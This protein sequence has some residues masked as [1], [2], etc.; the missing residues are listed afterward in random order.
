MTDLSYKRPG[1]LIARG[2]V[3][4]PHAPAAEILDWPAPAARLLRPER[5]E[6]PAL[7]LDDVFGARWAGWARD[8]AA[9]KGA[10]PDYVV[11]GL[12][13]VAGSLIGNARWVS[14]WAG[15]AEPPILWVMLIGNPSA[16]KS[17]GLDAALGPLRALE[18]EVRAAEEVALADWRDR[19]RLA[20]LAEKAWEKAT[21]AAL[22]R[23][24][25]LPARPAA[26]DPGPKPTLPR[27]SV[28]DVAV[29]R[30][31]ALLEQ[32]L[33]GLLMARDE[34]S[35]WIHSMTRYSGGSDRPFWLEAYG[36]RPYTVE[37]MGREPV[38]V[39]HLSVGVVG[40]IQPDRL[41]KL[42]L[43]AGDDDGLVARVLPFWPDP[44]PITRPAA[45]SDS[46]FLMEALRRLHGLR[47][48]EGSSGERRPWLVPLDGG[49]CDLFDDF[50]QAVRAWEGSEEGLLLSF[51]GK[52]PGMA[53]RLALILA[54]LDWAAEGGD[55]PHVITANHLSRATHFLEAYAL[56]MARRTYSEGA[57]S[58]HDR[59]AR[60]LVALIREKGWRSFT[61]REALR[62]E[63]AGLTTKAELGPA[64]EALV[65][66]D[67]LWDVTE[68]AGRKGGRRSPR[69]AVNPAILEG[70]Q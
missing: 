16:N 48:H 50:R 61:T 24:E 20:K 4:A 19:A 15:W 2:Q 67:A 64:L 41:R 39:E 3:P 7:P 8:A 12:L 11:A 32:R 29:E 25:E 30:L 59:A 43:K 38:S 56:P 26:A 40:G 49:A 23:G 34:L 68:P 47:M 55:E 70:P 28:S 35:G 33:Q 46:D 1:I 36:G 27:L 14:P 9:A 6:P 5:P 31:A 10:P 58:A 57:A 17:P 62:A 52:L 45:V 37:R 63:R 21:T 66:G 65:E 13:A 42:L 22:E 69:Y 18:R 54:Y 51:M 44:A 60:R 53:L